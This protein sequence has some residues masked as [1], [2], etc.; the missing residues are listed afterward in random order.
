MTSL[1]QIVRI[2]GR[3]P[4]TVLVTDSGL[5]GLSVA[6]EIERY[7]RET[8]DGR[9]LRV[10]FASALPEAGRGYNT[11][12]SAERKAR[13]FAAALAGMTRAVRP[14]V[15]L[16]ACN[17]LSVLLPRIGGAADVPVLGIVGLGVDMLEERLRAVG[18]STAVVFATETTVEAGAH[19][20]MLIERGIADERIVTQACP[21]LASEIER[22]ATSDLVASMIDRFAAEAMGLMTQKG[23][24]VIAGLCCT[25]YGYSAEQFREALRRHGARS[26]EILDPNLR[27]ARVLFPEGKSPRG[28]GGGVSIRVVSRAEISDAEVRSIA[29]LIHPASAATAAA[30]RAWERRTDLFPFDDHESG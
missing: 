17:T 13:V 18:G 12:K 14:D 19:R 27:M 5:G 26:V 16:V 25:H 9:S 7:A 24:P 21:R 2:A 6:A 23:D 11:M 1:E 22:D 4:I 3:G 28:A 15:V 10:V 30:L 20:A 29:A 8:G